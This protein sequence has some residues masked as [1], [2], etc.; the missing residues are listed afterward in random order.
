MITSLP[1]ILIRS[2]STKKY[3][4]PYQILLNLPSQNTIINIKEL[5]PKNNTGCLHKALWDQLLPTAKSTI[6]N[7]QCQSGQQANRTT[8]HS[9]DNTDHSVADTL[10]I[11]TSNSVHL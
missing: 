11:Y 8:A 2:L 9:T 6:S 1:P 7:A 10:P 4:D 5:Q 3:G